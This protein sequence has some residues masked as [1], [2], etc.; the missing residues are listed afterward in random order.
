MIERSLFAIWATM[1]CANNDAE[2]VRAAVAL[3]APEVDSARAQMLQDL[4]R[5]RDVLANLGEKLDVI[6]RT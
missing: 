4:M 2:I 6:E 3:A 1:L 5:V